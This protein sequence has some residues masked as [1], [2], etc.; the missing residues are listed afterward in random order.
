MT[1][2][3]WPA[4][5]Q[6]EDLAA[7]EAVPL[8]DRGLPGTT[9]DLLARA[10]D[11]WPERVAIPAAPKQVTVVYTLPV[12]SV[13]KPYK[14]VLRAETAREAIADALRNLPQVT[15]VNAVVNG[16]AVEAVVGLAAGGDETPVKEALD[17]FAVSWRFDK[18][19]IQ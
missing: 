8:A 3:L 1:D 4:Y 10:A 2:L 16:D 19:E 7:I 13:G 14:P 5:A 9:Y 18:Q 11:L 6:S 17:R 15:S 12:T